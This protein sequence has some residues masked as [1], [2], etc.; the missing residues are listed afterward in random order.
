[1]DE[2]PN[3]TKD[4][5]ATVQLAPWFATL[6]REFTDAGNRALQSG[7]RSDYVYR[8]IKAGLNEV[9]LDSLRVNT[10]SGVEG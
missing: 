6:T 9:L 5:H 1:M 3:S 2:Q 4:L 8:A 10:G 7:V